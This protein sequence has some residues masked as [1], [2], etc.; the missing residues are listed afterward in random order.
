MQ[1]KWPGKCA[2]NPRCMVRARRKVT[3]VLLG[4]AEDC[5]SSIYIEPLRYMVLYT[6]NI[7]QVAATVNSLHST[8]GNHRERQGTG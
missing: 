3:W 2:S 7:G 8:K 4:Q 1:Q 6:E 5:S